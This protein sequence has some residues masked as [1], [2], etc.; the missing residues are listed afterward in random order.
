MDAFLSVAGA[1]PP[2]IAPAAVEASSVG[3]HGALAAA[4]AAP[5][6]AA[7]VGGS[8]WAMSCVATAAAAVGVAKRRSAKATKSRAVQSVRHASVRSEEGASVGRADLFRGVGGAAVL[9]ALAPSPAQALGQDE[10]KTLLKQ[11]GT[12]Q[13]MPAKVPDGFQVVVEAVGL[14]ESA[15]T[16]R[17]KLGDE[18]YVLTFNCPS[19]WV[20]AKPNIDFNGTAGTVQAND[21]TKGDSAILFVQPQYSKKLAEMKKDDYST[22]LYKAL[23]QKGKGLLDSITI[24]TFKDIPGAPGYKQVQFDWTLNTGAGFSV[25]RLGYATF[26]Q[27]GSTNNLQVL[28]GGT[29]STRWDKME[30]TLI[31]MISSFRVDLVPKDKTEE[32]IKVNTKNLEGNDEGGLVLY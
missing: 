31:D 30:K 22:I 17:T 10:A 29:T 28:W 18:P 25:N 4:A 23:T 27:L 20:I 15:G 6:A 8:F 12:P 13:L 16:S 11:Y 7:S 1:T 19:N 9:G 26:A 32:V 14:T 5:S 24:N 21:Y 3:P 2:I